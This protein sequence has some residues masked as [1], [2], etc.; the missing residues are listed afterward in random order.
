MQQ[1]Y[2]KKEQGDTSMELKDKL[3]DLRTHF[4]Y[5][6]EEIAN[7]LHVSRQAVSRWETGEAKPCTE[8]LLKL[9]Q[10]YQVSLYELE[11]SVVE[12]L[13]FQV[14]LFNDLLKT[15]VPLGI[16][17]QNI[18]YL[19]MENGWTQEQY[20]KL[21]LFLVQAWE[22][23]NQWTIGYF[24]KKLQD[25]LITPVSDVV[26]YKILTAYSFFTQRKLTSDFKIYPFKNEILHKLDFLLSQVIP[27]PIR[28][29]FHQIQHAGLTI[30][31]LSEKEP[32]YIGASAG[33]GFTLSG[34]EHEV[35][36]Y[37]FDPSSPK[38]TPMTQNLTHI[39]EHQ[40]L[41]LYLGKTSV[42]EEAICDYAYHKGLMLC[43]HL[44]HPAKDLLLEAMYSL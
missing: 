42:I 28:H 41:S 4:R 9:S 12:N 38:T 2:A 31:N 1:I 36:V 6:Q 10:L 5:S 27:V 23:Y 3:R 35:E 17:N 8:N 32:A 25:I 43:N 16:L 18:E 24:T 7:Y 22:E 37:F 20:H 29:F 30:E 13:S 33:C 11:D 39:E 14:R 19:V 15:T 40:P 34:C 21:N 44:H 26:V